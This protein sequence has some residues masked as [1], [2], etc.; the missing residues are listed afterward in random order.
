M[1][2][3]SDALNAVAS[4]LDFIQRSDEYHIWGV[5]FRV[6]ESSSDER[7]KAILT[8][9]NSAGLLDSYDVHIVEI[10]LSW[11]HMRPQRRREGFPSW[12]PLGWSPGGISYVDTYQGCVF[13]DTPR[14]KESLSTNLQSAKVDPARM[15]QNISLLLKTRFV[16][17][18]FSYVN[19][20]EGGILIPLGQGFS[21]MGEILW[22]K[23]V[24][25]ECEVKIAMI[26]SGN[27]A[28]FL[29]LRA[30]DGYSERIGYSWFSPNTLRYWAENNLLWCLTDAKLKPILS[31]ADG[32]LE[33]LDE[34]RLRAAFGD[35][36]EVY[37]G[38]EQ[39]GFQE[40]LIVLG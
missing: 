25:V 33:P 32:E 4:T 35:I 1:T 8:S 36:E 5:P 29:V 6:C 7:Q 28:E 12:S 13:V 40:E 31:S 11:R 9:S 19:N 16:T 2:H 37:H 22:D 21:Y 30:H 39:D 15:A 20:S 3:D 10:Y 34:E 17:V 38:Y 14:G 26:S 27:G 24:E 23:P 18:D